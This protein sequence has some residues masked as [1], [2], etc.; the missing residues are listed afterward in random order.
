MPKVLLFAAL[1]DAAGTKELHSDAPTVRDL[2]SGLEDR[3]GELFSQ[4][5][6]K[7]SIVVDGELAARNSDRSLAEVEEVALLPPFAGG[8]SPR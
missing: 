5:L 1:R 7:A 4:R 8:A 2:I 3:F 6:E